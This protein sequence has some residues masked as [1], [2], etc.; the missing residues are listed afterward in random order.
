VQ[1]GA[2]EI[3][4]RPP[5]ALAERARGVRGGAIRRGGEQERVVVERAAEIYTA[6]LPELP[7]LGEQRERLGVEDDFASLSSLGLLVAP[8]PLG[9]CVAAVDPDDPPV[10]IDVSPA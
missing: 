7:M 6:L 1:P 9:L 8:A 5:V 10:E 2:A 3:E 4:S